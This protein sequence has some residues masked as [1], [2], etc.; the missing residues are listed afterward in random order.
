[1]AAPG[2]IAGWFGAMVKHS[3]SNFRKST[4]S[5]RRLSKTLPYLRRSKLPP[6]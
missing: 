6:K 5:A 3:A 1:M 2:G 4:N